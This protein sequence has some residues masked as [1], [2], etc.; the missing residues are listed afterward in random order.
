[1]SSTVRFRGRMLL[2]VRT[3]LLATS[4]IRS[5]AK[6]VRTNRTLSLPLPTPAQLEYHAMEMA[7]FVHFN[8]CTF[9]DCEQNNPPRPAEV[10]NPTQPVDTDQWVKVAASL[11][12]K[13]VC[14]TAHHSGGF[15][16]WQTNA[17]Q[18]GMRQSPYMAGK[19]DIVKDFVASCRTHQI[20]PCFY[21]I[22][23]WDSFESRSRKANPAHYLNTQ[24]QMVRELLTQHGQIDRL[25][26]DFYG[27]AC[28]QFGA[29]CPPGSFPEGWTQINDLVAAASSATVLSMPGTAGCLLAD[30][31]H[32]P[33]LGNGL[34]VL[35]RCMRARLL[36]GC[37]RGWVASPDSIC[38]P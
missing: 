8:V 35:F 27:T 38:P 28:R 5:E 29:D 33:E 10:F 31:S 24:L 25:W 21:I 4:T 19:G 14:L 2:A 11:G 37:V 3:L 13:Q 36:A 12:A 23:D 16:L 7:M 18:Y 34:H 30:A 15:A 9:A 32:N 20:S 17:T 1:M 22:P 6:V 26:F